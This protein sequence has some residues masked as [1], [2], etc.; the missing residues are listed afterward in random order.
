MLSMTNILNREIFVR[1]IF[2][3]PKMK[4]FR[5]LVVL[6]LIIPCFSKA[7]E[8]NERKQEES[9][10]DDEEM[11]KKARA[12]LL[13]LCSWWMCKNDHW[14][15]YTAKFFM[16]AFVTIPGRDYPSIFRQEALER[17]AD[18]DFYNSMEKPPH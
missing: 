10:G 5:I 11:D 1:I 3:G 14:D 16:A 2:L 8:T 9:L 7:A 12:Q 6:M 4:I 15:H 17:G 18:I 13:K